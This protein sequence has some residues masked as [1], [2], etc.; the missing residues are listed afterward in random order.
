MVESAAVSAQTSA[1]N[2]PNGYFHHGFF[3]A[4]NSSLVTHAKRNSGGD[5]KIV[6]ACVC[7][8]VSVCLCMTV[9]MCM[10]VRVRACV[11][12]CMCV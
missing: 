1:S 10:S 3:S 7:V 4:I 12:V 9:V 11:S 8:R 2:F 6:R 5:T